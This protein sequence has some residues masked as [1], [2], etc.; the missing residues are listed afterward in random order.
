MNHLLPFISFQ[1]AVFHGFATVKCRSKMKQG[2][3][4]RAQPQTP[5]WLERLLSFCVRFWCPPGGLILRPP[6]VKN[7]GCVWSCQLAQGQAFY[8]LVWPGNG[9]QY[10]GGGVWLLWLGRREC[11][12]ALLPDCSGFV[13]I[14]KIE[15][16]S[17][18][19]PLHVI[20]W[21][22]FCYSSHRELT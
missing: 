14:S 22:D 7:T 10:R 5:S 8:I 15:E 20:F 12:E 2:S 9:A 4:E 17:D 13:V 18:A 6:Q 1:D 19:S 3:S 16:A 11:G 21:S